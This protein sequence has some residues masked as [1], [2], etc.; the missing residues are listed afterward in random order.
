MPQF[1]AGRSVL[2]GLVPGFTECGAPMN[3]PRWTVSVLVSCGLAFALTG[4]GEKKKETG[5]SQASQAAARVNSEEV[6]VHQINQLLQQQR[7]VHPD[8]V[9]GA[10][11]QIL[12][13]LVD[14][15]LAVQRTR[16]L[17]IHQDPRV[18]LQLEAAKRDVLARA[19]AEHAGEAV[20][21][22]NAEAVQKY[23]DQRPLLFGERRIYDI[24]EL[25]IEATAEQV[26]ALRVA[27]QR[28]PVPADFMAH[29]KSTGLR[30]N[31]ARG[32]RAAEQLPPDVLEGLAGLKD[33]QM[34]LLP[35]AT[36]ALVVLLVG[37]RAAPPDE[38]R[39]KV[40]VAQLL[41]SEAKR[42]KVLAD[43]AALRAAAKIEYL[44]KFA[45][46][47]ASAPAAATKPTPAPTP[48]PAAMPASGMAADAI[49]RGM[50]VKP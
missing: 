15:E 10:S 25:D 42:V 7:G 36:G 45:E 41:L 37:S 12:E 19:F 23:M 31:N 21:K 32:S 18:M 24:H 22:P 3:L 40:A 44:G 34:V 49:N 50:G 38:A 30:F 1:P 5:A 14:Q 46:A 26:T 8:Q 11:K 20:A 29:L 28:A 48:L 39:S 43:V 4:C 27:M 13:L 9:A 35:S 6:T 17:K 2:S 33:N 16:E 47:A